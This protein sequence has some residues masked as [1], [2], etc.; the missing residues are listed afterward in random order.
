M[1]ELMDALRVDL[2]ESAGLEVEVIDGVK[3]VYLCE[4]RVPLGNSW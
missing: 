3:G 4:I 1:E 2:K